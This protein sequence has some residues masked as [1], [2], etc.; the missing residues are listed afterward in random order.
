MR[1]YSSSKSIYEYKKSMC[2]YSSPHVY[3][4]LCVRVYTLAT[5]MQY[6]TDNHGNN[7]VDNIILFDSLKTSTG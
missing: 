2:I 3:I 5:E 7:L 1:I 6:Q 4:Y